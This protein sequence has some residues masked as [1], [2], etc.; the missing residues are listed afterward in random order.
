MFESIKPTGLNPEDLFN[1]ALEMPPDER[2]QF[3]ESSCGSN[4]ELLREVIDLLEFAKSRPGLLVPPDVGMI[5]EALG[6]FQLISEC[7]RGGMGIVFEATD[8]KLLRKVALKVLPQFL[9]REPKSLRRFTKEAQTLAGLN[10][11][12]I[13][14][15][16]SLDHSNGFH[17]LSMEFVEGVTLADILEERVLSLNE[18]LSIGLQV[19][20]ALEAAHALGICHCDLKPANIMVS[21]EG[22]ITLLDFGIAR[23]F[24]HL[25]DTTNPVPI[26]QPAAS[27]AFGTP[28]YMAPEQAAGQTVDERTDLWAM[29][30]VLV[31]CLTGECLAAQV[32][33]NKLKLKKKLPNKVPRKLVE[34]LESCLRKNQIQRLGTATTA[35][36]VF[37]NL[38][39]DSNNS[40]LVSGM[41][42]SLV[43]IVVAFLYLVFGRAPSGPLDWLEVTSPTSIEGK[44]QKGEMLWRKDFETPIRT[45]LVIKNQAPSTSSPNDKMTVG[46]VVSNFNKKGNSSLGFLDI[47]TGQTLWSNEPAWS[48]PVNVT[49]PVNYR[50]T[51]SSSWP[52]RSDPV[53]INGI[54]DARWYS[55]AIEALDLTGKVLSVYHHPG[56]LNIHNFAPESG[57]TDSGLLLFGVNSSARFNKKLNPFETVEHPGCILLLMPPDISGQA[58]PYSEDM[59]EYRDWPGMPKAREYAYLLVPLLCPEIDARVIE[60]ETNHHGAG[61]LGY[62]AVVRDG[63]LIQ[64]DQDL[65]PLKCIVARNTFADSV[66]QSG[67]ASEAP[68]LYIREGVQEWVDLPVEF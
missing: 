44:N 1:D 65:Y 56:P 43:V 25:L 4:H 34:L 13:A 60:V 45:G 11:S 67:N 39:R 54:R 35:R 19:S 28:N 5:P 16:Y 55:F 29:G 47:K 33:G 48:I 31:E 15:L 36:L 38:L 18:T 6:P 22:K 17:F 61:N 7:G 49:G 2:L 66:Y 59:P 63:R 23:A 68:F 41:A 24:G 46:C 9:S 51:V 32:D 37:E 57:P 3:L 26:L 53:I 52:D 40:R 21:T 62:T 10:H 58:F 8:K 30:V 20:L 27:M 14:T 64:L 12:N 42:G 50:W